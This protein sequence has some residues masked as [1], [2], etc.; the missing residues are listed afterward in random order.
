MH[1]NSLNFLTPQKHLNLQGCLD[2]IHASFDL[3]ASKHP[4]CQNLY[5]FLFVVNEL[6]QLKGK[7]QGKILEGEEQTAPS[8]ESL[9]VDER[10]VII[11]GMY[12]SF[13]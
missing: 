2:F 3:V 5:L 1:V 7:S 10:Q 13:V 11:V 9:A 8:I 6:R 12:W 4:F